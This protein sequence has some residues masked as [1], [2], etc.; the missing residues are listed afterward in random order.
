MTRDFAQPSA[1]PTTDTPT[2]KCRCGGAYLDHDAGH[3]AHHAVFGHRPIRRP[4]P[5]PEPQPAAG[6]TS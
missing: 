2:A 6:V 3:A 5:Q 1:M 4:A